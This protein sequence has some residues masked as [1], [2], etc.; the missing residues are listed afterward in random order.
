[1]NLDEAMLELESFEND[2][3]YHEYFQDAV[4]PLLNDYKWISELIVV[5]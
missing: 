1:M 3:G 5:I 4:I 2:M